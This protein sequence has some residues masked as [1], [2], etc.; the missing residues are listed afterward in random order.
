M[1][2]S[3]NLGL[4]VGIASCGW[5]LVRQV[6]EQEPDIVAWGSLIFQDIKE[7]PEGKKE[8]P[9]ALRGAQRRA[10]RTLRRRRARKRALRRLFSE[11]GWLPATQ[12][13]QDAFLTQTK[14][15]GRDV[16]PWALRS[17]AV[18]GEV[19]LAELA[20]AI[21]HLASHRGFLSP[22]KQRL[23]GIDRWLAL[24]DQ[25]EEGVEPLEDDRPVQK[26]DEDVGQLVRRTIALREALQGQTVGQYA[27]RTLRAG[28]RVRSKKKAG[29]KAVEG[30]LP[31]RFVLDEEFNRIWDRQATYHPEL[32]DP[33]LRATV[34]DLVFFQRPLDL[35]ATSTNDCCFIPGKRPAS[36]AWTVAQ[37][38]RMLE[39][40][41]NQ[42]VM[43]PEEG[44][45]PLSRSERGAVFGALRQ[46]DFLSWD[47]AKRA[48][49]LPE[50]ARFEGE[51]GQKRRKSKAKLDREG[52]LGNRT[53][54]R[55]A[56]AAP[57]T[58]DAADESL[59]ERLVEVLLTSREPANAFK[60]LTDKLGVPEPEAARLVTAQ[61][62]SGYRP[63]C[64]KA[65][66]RIRE[67]ML[68]AEEP[69]TFDQA[70]VAAGL[71]R[72]APEERARHDGLLPLDINHQRKAGDGRVL[73]PLV[74]RAYRNA[75]RVVN[76][77][78]DAHGMP[79]FVHIEL[80]RDLTRGK[81]KKQQMTNDMAERARQRRDAEAQVRALLNR[82]PA[83]RVTPKEVDKYLLAEEMDW[84]CPYDPEH[85]ADPATVLREWDVEHIVP[86]GDT[87]DDSWINKTVA[88]VG[89]NR[90]KGYRT[91]YEWMV[92]DG[93]NGGPARFAQMEVFLRRRQEK[94]GKGT[95]RRTF[96][97]KM[98]RLW[99]A[100][101]PEEFVGRDL[102]ATGWAAREVLSALQRF[103]PGVEVVVTTGEGCAIVRREL[104]LR[105]L[106]P[107]EE[108]ATEKRRTDHRHHAVDALVAALT[109]R[110]LM[111][112]LV[113]AYRHREEARTT[114]ERTRLRLRLSD[115]WPG[116]RE[117]VQAQL[118]RC[119]VVHVPNRRIG[120]ELHNE[121]PIARAK[122]PAEVTIQGAVE[123]LAA[124]RA[125]AGLEARPPG[126]V[127][128]GGCLVRL[129][130]QGRAVA[131]YPLD[132]NHHLEI[133]ERATTG[134]RVRW[135]EAVSTH[136]A[137]ERVLLGRPLFRRTHPDGRLV[138]HLCKG[139]LVEW[140]NDDGEV[141]VRRITKFSVAGG[142]ELMLVMPAMARVPIGP[143][144]T[145]YRFR[146]RSDLLRIRR[147]VVLDP[148]G[149]VVAAEPGDV[150]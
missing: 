14:V 90:A 9:L 132:S 20:K 109:S 72:L 116:F 88:P 4:D 37:E 134:Q 81:L 59:R 127:R 91:P 107:G 36:R 78:V 40:I 30:L 11:R 39:D 16:H 113:G 35:Y 58:W 25:I 99:A 28:Q 27:Y 133:W 43:V 103:A 144:R 96:R 61:L 10:R 136:E 55:L 148:L 3:M 48:A 17:A 94:V 123:E 98:D 73:H 104:G 138:L 7:D 115:K 139:D 47:D 67:A 26:E 62:E 50:D 45:R 1:G 141:E 34:H 38:V 57:N 42:R 110:S 106:L 5:A 101:R 111:R 89:L 112:R 145:P 53:H 22:R 130:R 8:S 83:E 75:A 66:R 129:D 79:D 87:L 142:L 12:S 118:A 121:K 15:A 102:A 100:K 105:N 97:R 137:R 44:V 143:D 114:E 65:L 71:A 85:Q 19:T 70:A 63:C 32:L 21:L 92:R 46:T 93:E 124:K 108:S 24:G 149:R 131:V 31:D 52:F 140:V 18:E 51:E 119:V 77:V 23:M 41:G 84:R 126:A 49:D 2:S 147:R 135:A 29:A 33:H 76:A 80:P 82:A 146:S 13:E 60:A 69:L 54:A 128:V 150:P 120:G 74:K 6:E 56:Q 117:R 122:W 86:R 125:A 68:Q 64:Q 95:A